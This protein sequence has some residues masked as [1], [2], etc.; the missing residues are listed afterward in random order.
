MSIFQPSYI[1]FVYESLF[2]KFKQLIK[3]IQS[4]YYTFVLLCC[5]YVQKSCN[6]L[7]NGSK[8]SI[9][10]FKLTVHS[11]MYPTLWHLHVRFVPY[12]WMFECLNLPEFVVWLYILTEYTVFYRKALVIPTEISTGYWYFFT[13]I[14]FVWLCVWG[15]PTGLGTKFLQKWH[16]SQ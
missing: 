9:P 8:E 4:E 15:N 5:D 10:C 3:Y 1:N 2:G 14:E 16:K 7:K 6:G 12:V 11:N 13:N